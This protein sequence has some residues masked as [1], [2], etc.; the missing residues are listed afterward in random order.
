LNIINSEWNF[1]LAK[2]A[3]SVLIFHKNP[4]GGRNGVEVGWMSDDER[5]T[6]EGESLNEA[7]TLPVDAPYSS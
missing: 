6:L 2:S 3:S 4:T 7:L 1:N 5:K